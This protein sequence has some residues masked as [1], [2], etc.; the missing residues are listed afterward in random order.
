MRELVNRCKHQ[1]K[2]N[3]TRSFRSSVL[4]FMYQFTSSHFLGRL[5]RT[6]NKLCSLGLLNIPDHPTR[7]F[8]R[9]RCGVG[10]PWFFF[11]VVVFCELFS[12]LRRKCIFSDTL[13]DF[14]NF[15]KF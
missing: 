1:F 14:S 9:Y 7:K 5:T 3:K 4:Q 15:R 12:T 10:T 6:L 11:V 2:T 13:A 8:Y